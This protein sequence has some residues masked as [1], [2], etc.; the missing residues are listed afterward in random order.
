MTYRLKRPVVVTVRHVT[1]YETRIGTRPAH[2]RAALGEGAPRRLL[3]TWHDA[4]TREGAIS[5]MIQRLRD[6]GYSG[7][8]RV[9]P[10]V[11]SALV[12]LAVLLVPTPAAAGCT[13]Y[14]DRTELGGGWVA[15]CDSVLDIPPLGPPGSTAPRRPYVEPSRPGSA[16]APPG[17]TSC[18]RMHVCDTQRRCEWRDICK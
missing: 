16:L 15:V 8:A 13:W 14:Q 10:A 7:V 5:G 4:A 11:A 6:A 1:E 3:G 12:F 9:L 2:W 17:S 18:R